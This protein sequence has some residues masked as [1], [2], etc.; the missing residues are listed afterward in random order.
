MKR[1]MWI[2]LLCCAML[3]WMLGGCAVIVPKIG[4]Y[5]PPEKGD[6][7][8]TPTTPTPTPKSELPYCEPQA[9]VQAPIKPY[10]VQNTEGTGCMLQKVVRTTDGSSVQS[11]TSYT[12]QGNSL[13]ILSRNAAGQETNRERWTRNAQGEWTKAISYK[14]DGSVLSERTQ[15]LDA[16]GRMTQNIYQSYTSRNYK[17]EVRQVWKGE[18]LVR[19]EQIQSTGTRMLWT[20]AYNAQGKMTQAVFVQTSAKGDE[21]RYEVQW[22]YNSKGLPVSLV[23]K[24]KGEE[25]SRQTWSWRGDGTLAKRE[26]VMRDNAYSYVNLYTWDTSS[27]SSCKKLPVHWGHGYQEPSYT[28]GWTSG[29]AVSQLVVPITKDL[30]VSS[31]Y[32]GYYSDYGYYGYYSYSSYYHAYGYYG[33]S[34]AMQTRMPPYTHFGM[35]VPRVMFVQRNKARKLNLQ[36]DEQGRMIQEAAFSKDSSGDFQQIWGRERVWRGAALSSDKLTLWREGKL[37]YTRTLRLETNN[38]GALSKRSLYH[39]EQL[40]EQQIWSYDAKGQLTSLNNRLQPVEM[41]NTLEQWEY[42][43]RK[44]SLNIQPPNSGHLVSLVWNEAGQLVKES[45]LWRERPEQHHTRSYEYVGAGRRDSIK[46][47]DKT[48]TSRERFS[49][50]QDGKLVRREHD[51]D[52]DGTLDWFQEHVFNAK[53]L[54]TQTVNSRTTKNQTS[55]STTTYTYSCQ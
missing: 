44:K 34:V 10:F 6:S 29:K 36:Y 48:R 50:N 30:P 25:Q 12:N 5:Q 19:K 15:S 39:N 23:H 47:G 33:G 31:G 3:G 8:K 52:N 43:D 1:S 40:L 4:D 26:I 28:P 42:G 53:K 2:S 46:Y 13:E 49:Y 11:Q 21:A 27:P 7:Q 22:E 24:A 41:A 17:T 45:L 38:A 35:R 55:Q 18:N 37:D 14:T 32:Y 16:K 54:L 51:A 9:L 20:W